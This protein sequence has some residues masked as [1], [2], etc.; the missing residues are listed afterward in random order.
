MELDLR[1]IKINELI[2]CKDLDFWIMF[3]LVPI[4]IF[5]KD[6]SGTYMGCN[7]AYEKFMGLSK[8]AIIGKSAYDL[9]PKEYADL[10]QFKDEELFEKEEVQVYENSFI[11]AGKIRHVV[12][13]KMLYRDMFGVVQGLVG[14]VIDVTEKKEAEEALKISEEKNKVLVQTIPDIMLVVTPEL[15]IVEF[16]QASEFSHIGDKTI[17][18]KRIGDV[19]PAPVASVFKKNVELSFQQKKV[20]P[21]EYQIEYED[22][23]KYRD[24]RAVV[25]SGEQALIMIRD[26]TEQK[27]A[28]EEILKL[29]Q[30]VEESP[31]SIIIID[32]A[33]TIIYVNAEYSRISGYSKAEIVGQNISFF[34][35]EAHPESFYEEIKET[36]TNGHQWQGEICNKRKNGDLYWVLVSISPVKNADGEIG[37]Y[38]SMELDLTEYKVMEDSLYRHNEELAAA[39]KALESTHLQMVQQEKLASIGQLA[40]GVGHEINNPVGFVSSNF[41]TLQKY[42]SG[43]TEVIYKYKELKLLQGMENYPGVSDFITQINQLEKRKKVDFVLED[44]P[45]LFKECEEGM[46]R[47]QDIAKALKLFVRSDRQNEFDAYDLNE[48]IKNTLIIAKNEVKYVAEVETDLREIPA[49]SAS[50]GQINQVLLNIIVNAAHAIT[51]KQNEGMGKIKIATHHDEN[52]A[53]CIIKDSGIGMSKDVKEKIFNAFFTTKPLGKGTGLGLSISYDIIVNKHEGT[54]DVESQEGVGTTFIIKLPLKEGLQKSV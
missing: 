49:F 53:Y 28:Q 46:Q 24:A 47:I 12:F 7:K 10:Y 30:A 14:A 54:L 3:D 21:F 2:A 31:G 43:I 41:D 38:L 17:L 40:A 29:S 15:T 45:I 16:K 9:V 48:G 19:L 52:F 8:E 13:H 42:F 18:G 20:R 6:Y 44:I 25:I 26:I 35:S 34:R 37:Y 36:V 11:V 50:S 1:S 39:Y 51:A 27:L 5:V 32:K 4:P 22:G 33:E 23:I